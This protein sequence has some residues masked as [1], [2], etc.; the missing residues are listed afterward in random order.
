MFTHVR[1]TLVYGRLVCLGRFDTSRNRG[2]P[3]SYIRPSGNRYEITGM[4]FPGMMSFQTS[5]WDRGSICRSVDQ[6]RRT[7]LL[8]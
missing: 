3:H 5:G 6:P 7:H 1:C 4:G 8:P 2:L